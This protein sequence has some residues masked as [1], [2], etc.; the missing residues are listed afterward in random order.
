MTE[1]HDAEVIMRLVLD[2]RRGR[3]GK[4]GLPILAVPRC[5][6]PAA[7][8]LIAGGDLAVSGKYLVPA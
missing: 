3:W 7:Q 2:A 4:P 8:W 5:Y 1:H 6:W